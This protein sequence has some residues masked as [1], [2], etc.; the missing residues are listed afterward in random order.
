MQ[1]PAMKIT[2]TKGQAF[3]TKLIMADFIKYDFRRVALQLPA[4][5]GNEN[6]FLAACTYFALVREGK[7]SKEENFN[8]FID[9][10]ES[11]DP[12]ETDEAEFPA[13]SGT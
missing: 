5:E 2:T 6:A 11:I 8:N 13:E 10:I 1:S 12:V 4:K 9:S 7:L 3:E